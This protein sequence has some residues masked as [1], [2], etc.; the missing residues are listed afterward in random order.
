MTDAWD[1]LAIGEFEHVAVGPSV[2]LLRVNGRSSR[3]RPSPEWRPTLIADHGSGPKRFEALPSPPDAEGVL[4]A[5]YSVPSALIAADARFWLELQEG[6]TV[7]LE[8]P[9][10]GTPRRVAG[11]GAA[12]A[13]DPEAAV[14]GSEPPAEG[15]DQLTSLSTEL[16][17]ARDRAAQLQGANETMT[18]TLEE[19]EIWRGELER[20][21][22]DTTTELAETRARLAEAHAAAEM[23]ALVAR[24][25]AD[26]LE[27]AAR[28]LTEAAAQARP[29][30]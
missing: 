10:P 24:A 29:Q 4:R 14:E 13:E 28:E 30:T 21:L 7:E 20:R 1:S 2:V 11:D 26:A 27:Q 23:E 3:P 9:A 6:E 17:D 22:A 19:L 25:E 12:P 18:S 16:A 8:A 5:A 15:S